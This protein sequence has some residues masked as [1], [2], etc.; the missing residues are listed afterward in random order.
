MAVSALYYQFYVPTC[1]GD[2]PVYRPLVV[3]L[4]LYTNTKTCYKN[5]ACFVTAKSYH[6]VNIWN[7]FLLLLSLPIMPARISDL[8]SMY[9][10][11]HCDLAL[12]LTADLILVVDD[13]YDIV[14]LIR[15]GLKGRPLCISFY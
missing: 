8:C 12:Y 2:A 5:S 7:I 4:S 3:Y 9:V 14:L 6:H 15:I 10:S 13:D 1:L 11:F